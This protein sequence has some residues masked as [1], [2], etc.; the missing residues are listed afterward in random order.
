[1]VDQRCVFLSRDAT[2]PPLPSPRNSFPCSHWPL[3]HRCDDPCQD[4]PANLHPKGLRC[5]PHSLSA[6]GTVWSGPLGA[7]NMN[8]TPPAPLQPRLWADVL[9]YFLVPLQ[10]QNILNPEGPKAQP[11]ASANGVSMS[12]LGTASLGTA[13]LCPAH[14]Q[15][16]ATLFCKLQSYVL[17]APG[18]HSVCL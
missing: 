13:S 18:R 1:M 16:Q 10:V 2:P 9:W 14:F 8:G 6:S 15:H 5:R 7:R 17:P 3:S 4:R 12:S 11:G